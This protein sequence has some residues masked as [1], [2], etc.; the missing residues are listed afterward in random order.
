MFNRPGK[1]FLIVFV[2]IV[3]FAAIFYIV[4]IFKPELLEPA[5]GNTALY[6]AIT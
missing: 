4:P 3:Y 2:L 1:H 6:F 5:A